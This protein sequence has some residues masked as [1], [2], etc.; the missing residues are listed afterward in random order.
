MTT[1]SN[2]IAGTMTWGV[3]GKNCN[4]KQMIDL[5]NCCIEN[6]ITTFDHADI[7]G[8]YTT[9][10]AFGKAFGDSK[11]NRQSIQFISKCGIQMNLENRT[12]AIKH[13]EYFYYTVNEAL[14]LSQKEEKTIID[15]FKNIKHDYNANIDKFNKAIN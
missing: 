13:Y 10:A 11:I 8:D 15:V 7:Y 5:M 4:T 3:W 9:E 12:N 1:F 2:I 14:F 6:N